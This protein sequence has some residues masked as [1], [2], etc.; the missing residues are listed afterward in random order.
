VDVS[1][2]GGSSP[3]CDAW[4]T[5]SIKRRGKKQMGQSRGGC[6]GLFEEQLINSAALFLQDCCA[7]V[8]S[9]FDI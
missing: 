5:D 7:A 9:P 2:E 3:I 6:F 4:I 1:L 8:D